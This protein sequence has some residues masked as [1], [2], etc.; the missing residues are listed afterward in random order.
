MATSLGSH[1]SERRGRS[2]KLFLVDGTAT[3]VIIAQLGMS[4]LLAAAAS[5]VALPDLISREEA[6]QT[7]V[8]LLVG[9]DPDVPGRDLVYVGEGDQ[10]RVRLASH[11]AEPRKDFFTRAVLIVSKDK[12]LTK[13]HGRYLEARI[14]SAIRNAGRAKLT[15]GTEPPIAG[16]LPESDIADMERVLE[17]L[18]LLLPVLGFDLLRSAGNISSTSRNEGDARQ[19]DSPSSSSNDVFTFTESG[20]SARAREESGEFVVLAGSLARGSEI[21]SCEDSVRRQRAQFSS[22][23]ILVPAEDGRLRFTR[24]IGFKSPSRA[25]SVVYGGNASGPQYWK[26]E[27]TRQSYRDWRAERLQTAQVSEQAMLTTEL[28]TDA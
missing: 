19:G 11:D 8:Y 13:A 14:I 27:G 21:D 6:D 25:A 4:S 15:N 9:P 24:D 22:D 12:N 16:R 26:H 5:R 18:E 7:G 17:E 28:L 2:L 23:G 1:R 3:G 10:V 20:T